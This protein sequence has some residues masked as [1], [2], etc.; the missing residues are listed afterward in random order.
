[1]LNRREFLT[2]TA[3]TIGSSVADTNACLPSV[4]S[5][6]WLT[7]VRKSRAALFLDVNSYSRSLAHFDRATAYLEGETERRGDATVI[8]G[9]HGPGIA[10][11]LSTHLWVDWNLPAQLDVALAEAEKLEGQLREWLSE[12]R[13]RYST[14]FE[15]LVCQRTLG[16]WAAA[17]NSSNVSSEMTKAVGQLVSGVKLAPAMVTAS[18]HAQHSGAA[19]V[20]STA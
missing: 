3:A 18:A 7:R 12:M 4:A 10:H 6:D 20:V 11:G 9:L 8:I 1:M 2:A 17:R 16:R 13:R 15:L 14:Q 19:Y 5:N